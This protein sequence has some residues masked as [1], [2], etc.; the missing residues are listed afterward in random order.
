MD[1]KREKLLENLKKARNRRDAAA[2][3]VRDTG[4]SLMRVLNYSDFSSFALKEGLIGLGTA[5]L[6]VILARAIQGSVYLAR[7]ARQGSS[8]AQLLRG[9]A[10]RI[11]GIAAEWLVNG[12]RGD[13]RGALLGSV[14]TV[15]KSER[16]GAILGLCLATSEMVLAETAKLEAKLRAQGIP[17]APELSLA[18]K[19]IW[20]QQEPFEVVWRRHFEYKIEHLVWSRCYEMQQDLVETY[21]NQVHYP[22]PLHPV[23]ALPALEKAIEQRKT[24]EDNSHLEW[25]ARKVDELVEEMRLRGVHVRRPYP[26]EGPLA[27]LASIFELLDDWTRNKLTHLF[28][29]YNAR[30]NWGWYDGM[31][32]WWYKEGRAEFRELL[33]HAGLRHRPPFMLDDEADEET[34]N[35]K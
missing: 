9:S 7:W 29:V 10:Q 11:G 23:W 3:G 21:L 31:Y 16:A 35:G 1:E 28:Q 8:L 33:K 6:G 26:G 5:G 25:M 22:D 24:G 17:P 34:T 14:A 20:R 32:D 27:R 19:H 13:L 18:A 4:H 2:R 15:A 30:H 12:V